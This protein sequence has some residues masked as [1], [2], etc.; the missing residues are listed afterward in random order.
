MRAGESFAR[1]WQLIKLSR[2][3]HPH[4]LSGAILERMLTAHNPLV[5]TE[6]GKAARVLGAEEGRQFRERMPAGI[7][8]VTVLESLF[9]IGGIWCEVTRDEEG[10][11]LKIKKDTGSFLG[12]GRHL[13]TIAIPFLAGIV[14]AVAPDAR[15]RETGDLLE[16]LVRAGP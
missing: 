2:T 3:W 16:V 13:E 8:E 11:L 15:V 5:V 6:I 12:G 1:D 4:D 7:D 9:L 14:E 10:A